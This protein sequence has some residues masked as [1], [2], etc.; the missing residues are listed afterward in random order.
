MD[1]AFTLSGTTGGCAQGKRPDPAFCGNINCYP[2]TGPGQA[3]TEE[4]QEAGMVF[5][6]ADHYA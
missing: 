6:K 3:E 5:P 4:K 1:M 2:L